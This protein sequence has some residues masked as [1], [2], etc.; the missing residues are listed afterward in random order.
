MSVVGSPLRARAGGLTG[1]SFR[2]ALVAA[3]AGLST[4]ATAGTLLSSVP[5]RPDPG[6]V[7][8]FYMHG[9]GIDDGGGASPKTSG[10][11]RRWPSATSSW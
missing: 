1:V 8:L 11:S 2:S 9:R 4:P 6:A 10:R 7:Y 3:L 5:E